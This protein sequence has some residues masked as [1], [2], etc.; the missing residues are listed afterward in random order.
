MNCLEAAGEVWSLLDGEAGQAERAALED[1]LARCS[2]CSEAM[3]EARRVHEILR[4]NAAEARAPSLEGAV[5]ARLGEEG[6]RS[7][8]ADPLAALAAG[9]AFLALAVAGVLWA[10][11]DSS[12]GLALQFLPGGW[13]LD[14]DPWAACPSAVF[15]GW[16]ACQVW[17]ARVPAAGALSAA[18]AAAAVWL[19]ARHALL[20]G[21][22]HER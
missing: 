5:L 4:G 8:E 18:A 14:P 11:W 21:G 19:G 15:E 9:A 1:H 7:V 2:A 20:E 22:C 12:W 16:R 10:G 17:A 6:P 13:R 3:A